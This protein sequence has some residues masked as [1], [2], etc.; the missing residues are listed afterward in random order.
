VPELG[1]CRSLIKPYLCGLRALIELW[2]GRAKV[3]RRRRR[4]SELLL[5]LL[6]SFS[7]S[8]PP[9]DLLPVSSTQQ[10]NHIFISMP[11]RK[12]R[13]HDLIIRWM[14]YELSRFSFR[15][16]I[17]ELPLLPFVP[18]PMHI[19]KQRIVVENRL[20]TQQQH[21]TQGQ[22]FKAL[23]KTTRAN[24]RAKGKRSGTDRRVVKVVDLA[25]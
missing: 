14:F 23:F 6:P 22:L 15:N 2:T 4:S 21:Q 17:H 24:E 9:F 11:L 16:P 13:T 8:D 12:A 25:R 1:S 10:L 7:R 20:R 5:L 3:P 18:T 19:L